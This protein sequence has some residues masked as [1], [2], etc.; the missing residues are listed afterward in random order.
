[1]TNTGRSRLT[2]ALHSFRGSGLLQMILRRR[3]VRN[4]IL[5]AANVIYYHDALWQTTYWL[6]NQILKY[7]GDVWSYQEIIYETRPDL[8]I[9]TG[10][11]NGGS[12]LFMATLLDYLNFGRIIT[13][14]IDA[15]RER[16]LHPRIQYVTASSIAPEVLES[17]R[18]S[19]EGA[20]RVMVILD[21]DHTANHVYQEMIGYGRLVTP[22]CYMIVEDSTINGHPV[23]PKFGPGPMEAIQ[24]FLPDHPEFVVDKH[25][26]RLALTQN[27]SGYLKRA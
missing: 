25:R 10:T 20:E 11:W 23:A 24:R 21:S 8:I 26:E 27:P 6:G 2:T 1:M 18:H 13:I 3:W 5:R 19:A 12:A 16:P 7:P 17:V 9:E 14:D 22:G 4:L 15:S